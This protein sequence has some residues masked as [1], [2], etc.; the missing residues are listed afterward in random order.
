M[1]RV[2][3]DHLSVTGQ[4][5]FGVAQEAPVLA[6]PWPGTRQL[7]QLRWS[8][9]GFEEIRLAYHLRERGHQQDQHRHD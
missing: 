7:R 5:R 2:I 4:W 3:C 8:A 1:D 9:V 6:P